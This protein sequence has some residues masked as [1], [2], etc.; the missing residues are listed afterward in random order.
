[1]RSVS[2]GVV[3]SQR[4]TRLTGIEPAKWAATLANVTVTR[5]HGLSQLG[6]GHADTGQ[7]L[8][9]V[10]VSAYPPPPFQHTGDTF[11]VPPGTLK[12]EKGQFQ[13]TSPSFRLPPGYVETSLST[14]GVPL[15]YRYRLFG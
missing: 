5:S 7:L 4:P 15:A 1:M 10:A 2:V 12:L 9:G 3:L 6:S 14:P 8:P 13:V 11:N